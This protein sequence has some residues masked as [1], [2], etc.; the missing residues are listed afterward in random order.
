MI[1][2]LALGGADA[3][4]FAQKQIASVYAYHLGM[5]LAN[6]HFHH[7]VALVQAQRAVV[8]EDTGQLVPTNGAVYQCGV[9][10]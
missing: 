5:E 3:G 10:G 2:R 8:Y 9:G 1:L 7:Q 6:E 4:Q